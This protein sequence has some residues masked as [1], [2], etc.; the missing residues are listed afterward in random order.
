MDLIL[1][2]QSKRFDELDKESQ[3][4][5]SSLLDNQE[6]L[7][8]DL[9][10]QI[11]AVSHMLSR[12]EFVL[13]QHSQTR[14][15]FVDALEQWHTLASSGEPLQQ[16]NDD[17]IAASKFH[18]QRVTR[19]VE[20]RI[21]ET[22]RFPAMGD[23][24]EEI[25]ENH[26]RTFQ[27]MLRDTEACGVQSWSDFVRWLREGTGIYWVNGK[28]GSR[29]STLMK[30]ISESAITTTELCKWGWGGQIPLCVAKGFFFGT[31]VHLS[32]DPK[33]VSYERCFMRSSDSNQS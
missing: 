32:N 29:K 16:V 1:T 3:N 13:D 24:F 6:V 20:V 25:A 5:V 31:A 10:D 30:Y 33:P 4:I 14:A 9:L 22:L 21:L 27:W 19:M 17:R 15:L 12:T 8:K 2:Q 26:Q 18:E 7:S 28:A 23:R 11:T